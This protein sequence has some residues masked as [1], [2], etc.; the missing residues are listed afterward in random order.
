MT[1][2][3]KLTDFASKDAL[4]AGSA[5]KKVKGTEIDDELN[6]ISDAI[7]TKADVNNDTLTNTTLA[8]P[9]IN[10]VSLTGTATVSANTTFSGTVALGGTASA[11]TPSAGDNDTS[12]ATTAYVQNEID[13]LI[14]VPSGALLPFAGTSAP[15]G[16]LLCYGQDVSRTTYAAL[17]TAIGT[18]YG[19]GDGST[20]FTLPD[21]RGY[22]VA[23]KDDMG[24]TAAS[25]LTTPDGTTLGAT[26]GSETHTLTTSEMPAHTHSISTYDDAT[27]EQSGD[28]IRSTNDGYNATT[29]N[30]NSTGGGSAHNNVQPTIVL[31]YIIKT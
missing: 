20:T 16:Y 17:F 11:T 15:T 13:L 6:A 23:G 12:V 24:G 5:L 22:V 27:S 18:T 29:H 19:V 14:F 26:G 30:T 9:T 8:N 1:D 25:R 31:N 7:V 4:P 3:T 28:G 2:Y 21:L 10:S